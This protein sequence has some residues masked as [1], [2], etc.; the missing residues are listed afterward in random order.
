MKKEQKGLL[1][2]LKEIDEICKK[3]NITYYISGGTVIGAVRHEGFIPWDDDIDIYM[4]RENWNRFRVL[5]KTCL[6]DRRVVECWENNKGFTNLLGRYMNKDTTQIQKYHLYCDCAMGQLIDIFVLDPIINDENAIRQYQKDVMLLSDLMTEFIMYSNRQPTCEEYAPLQ[7]RIE[8]EGKEKVISEVFERLERYDEDE[9]DYYILRWGGIPHLFPKEMFQTPKY[10]AFEDMQVPAPSK[11]S[12]YLI[13]LY[14]LDWM[15]IPPHSEKLV[16]STIF[17]NERSYEDF[18]EI[19]KSRVINKKTSKNLIK[20]KKDQFKNLP[21]TH[22]VE[23]IKCLTEGEFV[24]KKLYKQLADDSIDVKKILKSGDHCTIEP[25]IEDYINMQSQ[26]RF[27]GNAAFGGYYSKMNPIFIDIGDDLLAIALRIMIQNGKIAKAARILHVREQCVAEPVEGCL[28]NIK[29]MFECIEKAS[30]MYEF[31]MVDEALE[32]I[33]SALEV[34]SN[35]ELF[36]FKL[37]LM[38]NKGIDALDSKYKQMLKCCIETWPNDGDFYKFAGDIHMDNA[39]IKHALE[40]YTKVITESK[41]GI[42]ALQI[43]KNI[44]ARRL[45]LYEYIHEKAEAGEKNV[46]AIITAWREIYPEDIELLGLYMGI[47]KE[48]NRNIL[49][50]EAI[51]NLF[52]K[53]V[54]TDQ[55]VLS[56]CADVLGWQKKC[57]SCFLYEIGVYKDGDPIQKPLED[58]DEICKLLN[59]VLLQRQGGVTE[60]YRVYTELVDSSDKCIRDFVKAKFD[61]DREIFNGYKKNGDDN[62]LRIDYNLK[63]GYLTG[64]EYKKLLKSCNSKNVRSEVRQTTDIEGSESFL[65][66]DLL[67]ELIDICAKNSIE[68][69]VGGGILYYLIDPSEERKYGLN[70]IELVV[71]GANATKLIC[72]CKEIPENRMLESSLVNSKLRSFDMYYINTESMEIDNSSFNRRS[73]LG[74]S[75]PIRVI[76]PQQTWL[77]QKILAKLDKLW[78]INYGYNFSIPSLT[79]KEKLSYNIF[80]KFGGKGDAVTQRIFRKILKLKVEDNTKGMYIYSDNRIHKH[81]ATQWKDKKEV[82]LFGIAVHVPEDIEKYLKKVY[83]NEYTEKI[84]QRDV[85]ILNG[86]YF[87]H[88]GEKKLYRDEG[89]W[90]DILS[91]QHR[92]LEYKIQTKE[93]QDNWIM[94]QEIVEGIIT[95]EFYIA[96]IERWYNLYEKQMYTELLSQMGNYTKTLKI[97]DKYGVEIN[98][99]LEK[100]Y[101]E[102]MRKVM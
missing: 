77:K 24:K 4:T 58:N 93:Y 49:A 102:S 78:R 25:I 82:Q 86:E 6:S 90:Q 84:F 15:Y 12:D 32:L 23:R 48:N 11:I 37:I 65:K 96:E 63:Y 83:G 50:D 85:L 98:T 51:I 8:K 79:T 74:I 94:A 44:D 28:K 5:S 97:K 70:S 31:G 35:K 7:K 47:R 27:I 59:A 54:D 76:R 3:N 13:Q 18:N 19:I 36:K 16:H 55:A 57:V 38:R 91:D 87:D 9:S 20:R 41:N 56:K 10:V 75:V 100:I 33:D 40:D 26:S 43:R 60:A 89:F 71:D 21:L 66:F 39:D 72:A 53:D 73:S 99:E 1:M 52:G 14:G 46:E 61:D 42:F 95:E 45:E 69:F 67:K 29:F 34:E 81:D 68:Y 64:D 30:D 22:E 2:L 62:A 88:E 101:R 17:D 80:Y 92:K